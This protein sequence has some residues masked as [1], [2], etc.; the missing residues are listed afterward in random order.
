[1]TTKN[2]TPDIQ[3]LPGSERVLATMPV[4]DAD[5]LSAYELRLMAYQ[6]QLVAGFDDLVCLDSLDF[7]PF[8]YQ[9]RAARTVLRRFR[10]RGLL[11]DE[12]GLGKT[13]EASLVLKE[14]LVR[15]MVE[16]V[17][18]L[19]PPG[20]VE[21]WR[22][23]L[24]SKFDLTGFVANTDE[25]FGRWGRRPGRSS[26]WSWLHWPR[27]GASQHR[28]V[29]TAQPYDLVIVDE[30]HHLKNRSS[31]S[32]KLVN[33]LQK[34]YILLLTATPG[35]EPIER[36]L[37]PDH[38]AQARPTEQ[39]QGVQP[40]VRRTRRSA[41][42]QKSRST[43]RAAERCDGAPFTRPDQHPTAAPPRPHGPTG[44]AP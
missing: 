13:I 26:R 5:A 17:L 4:G 36:T 22:E 9:I 2:I 19:T 33:D 10:G 25:N 39:P 38:R 1:M 18:I 34:K 20:L 15:Q 16:R 24:A 14:Y 35:A 29:I 41:P 31:V 6:L 3:I 11:G 27:R 12:V 43:A 7:E 8:D 37:Q 28:K 23:E 32:W 30:A 42:A 44:S 21:Q 40:P